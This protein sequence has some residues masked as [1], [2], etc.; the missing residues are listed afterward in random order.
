MLEIQRKSQQESERE[1][2]GDTKAN[3]SEG[4]RLALFTRETWS[5]RTLC[6][7]CLEGNKLK[8][9]KKKKTTFKR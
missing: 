9:I 6:L 1:G 2:R 3:V 4:S 7:C 8:G 5:S